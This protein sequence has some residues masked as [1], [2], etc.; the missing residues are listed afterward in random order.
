MAAKATVAMRTATTV[1]EFIALLSPSFRVHFVEPLGYLLHASLRLACV[2]QLVMDVVFYV[3]N[4][5]FQLLGRT[6][7]QRYLQVLCTLES[8]LL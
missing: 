7:W 8:I 3:A 4:G 2:H 1:V 5:L 6:L